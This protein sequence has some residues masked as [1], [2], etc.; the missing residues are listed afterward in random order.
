MKQHLIKITY[1]EYDSVAELNDTERL[2]IREAEN[3]CKNAYAPYSKFHVGCAILLS[4]GKIVSGNNQENAAYP[5]GLCAERVAMFAASSQYPDASFVLMAVV[6][7]SDN[8]PV[9]FPVPPCGACRQVM[10]EYEKRG[11][12]SFKILIK[13]ESGKIIRVNNVSD[14]LPLM[15]SSSQLRPL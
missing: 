9:N 13:G 5:S 14:L 15:F 2:V 10:A 4:N 12:S 6:A 11:N 7:H 8:F 1:V 3:A